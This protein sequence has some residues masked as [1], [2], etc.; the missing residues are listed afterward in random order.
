MQHTVHCTEYSVQYSIHYFFVHHSHVGCLC[1]QQDLT[2]HPVKTKLRNYR[3]VQ[4]KLKFIITVPFTIRP[5]LARFGFLAQTVGYF[6]SR[7]LKLGR[8]VPGYTLK[9]P[10]GVGPLDFGI[11]RLSSQA[12]QYRSIPLVSRSMRVFFSTSEFC[13]LNLFL[14][15]F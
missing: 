9:S 4:Q 11:T 7:A 10:R 15:L 5:G 3:P 13:Q 2:S 12:T 14:H 8:M 6:H 1:T